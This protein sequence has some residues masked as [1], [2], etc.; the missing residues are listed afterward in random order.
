[1]PE[2]KIDQIFC[3]FLK[4]SDIVQFEKFKSD[5]FKAANV[6]FSK[7]KNIKGTLNIFINPKTNTF[8]INAQKHILNIQPQTKK[9][10]I[11]II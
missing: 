5:N 7:V 2:I 9:F 1:M 4:L 3:D 11:I 6:D 10:L 8:L